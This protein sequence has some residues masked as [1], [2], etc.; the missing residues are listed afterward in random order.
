METLSCHSN[1]ST[2]AKAIKTQCYEHFCKISASSPLWLLRGWV[3]NN[4]SQIK[5]FCCH[6]TQSNS[7]VWTKFIC[8]IE[9][10][11]MNISV[12]LLSKYL[13]WG[14]NKCQFPLFLYESMETIS[15]HSNQSS[16]PIG[17]KTQLFVP[18][19]Y[20][21]YMWNVERIGFTASEEMSFEKFDRRRTTTNNGCLPIL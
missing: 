3:F 14:S 20:R 9:D 13:Q 16:Y 18:P 2:W 4:F 15:C 21:C 19:A 5:P 1:E 17:T 11:S 12:K 7:A 10:Y 6:G 8:F